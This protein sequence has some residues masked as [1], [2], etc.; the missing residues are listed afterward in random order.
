[1]RRRKNGES[2][3]LLKKSEKSL[4]IQKKILDN[5]INN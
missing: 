2:T 3:Y 5:K 1:M 4:A